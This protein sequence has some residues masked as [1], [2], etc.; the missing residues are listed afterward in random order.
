MQ[1]YEAGKPMYFATR[2]IISPLRLSTDL[3]VAPVQLIYALHTSLTS[4]LNQSPS[5]PE[6]FA[7]HKAISAHVKDTLASIGFGFVPLDRTLAANGMSAVRY[8]PGVAAS[9]ILPKLAE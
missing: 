7:A 5:L 1:A 9:D 3:L 8:P 6:R 4:I 2:R